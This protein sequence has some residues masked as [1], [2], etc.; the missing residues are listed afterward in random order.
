MLYIVIIFLIV[1]LMYYS[2]Y[3]VISKPKRDLLKR[4][5]TY[6]SDEEKDLITPTP[7]KADERN[8]RLSL[9]DLGKLFSR[10]ERLKGVRKYFDEELMKSGILLRGEEFIVVL[11]ISAALLASLVIIVLQSIYGAVL[12]ALFGLY[13]PIVYLGMQKKKRQKLFNEQLGEV[14][15]T[16]SN[17]LKSGHSLLKA[18]EVVANESPDPAAQEISNTVK[19]MQLGIATEEALQ[20]LSKR[21]ESRDLELMITAILIQRQVGGNL[22][23]VLDSIADTIR[24]RLR[25]EGEIKTLTA[26]G[27]LSGIIICFLPVGLGIFFYVMNPEYIMELFQDPRG[28]LMLGV[29]VAAQLVGIFFIRKIVSIDV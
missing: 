24:E 5:K 3:L 4:L 18:L 27:R 23:E 20:N 25:I 7:L 17:A 22:A 21:I 8:L 6:T 29:A 11:L 26:Q 14:L 13:V 15:T 9:K 1:F 16:M 10:V 2:I 28:M 12:G 19:E